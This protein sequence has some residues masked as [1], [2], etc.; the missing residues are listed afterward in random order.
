MPSINP[1][2]ENGLTRLLDR[3]TCIHNTARPRGTPVCVKCYGAFRNSGNSLAVSRG[4][5]PL[6]SLLL[7]L[8]TTRVNLLSSLSLK[9]V[10]RPLFISAGHH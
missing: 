1:V 5:I 7:R 3:Q 6:L 9:G 2:L 8:C 4:F 10:H